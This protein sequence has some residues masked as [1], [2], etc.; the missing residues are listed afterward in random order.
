MI[1]QIAVDVAEFYGLLQDLLSKEIDE[2]HIIEE[3]EV[4]AKNE[5]LDFSQKFGFGK[6]TTLSRCTSCGTTC[7]KADFTYNMLSLGIPLML[8]DHQGSTTL[9]DLIQ[10]RNNFWNNLKTCIGCNKHNASTTSKYISKSPEVMII[11]IDRGRSGFTR[12]DARINFPLRNFIPN[13]NLNTNNNASNTTYDLFAGIFFNDTS[14][15]RHFKAICKMKESKS[16][17]KYNDKICQVVSFENKRQPSKTVV[18]FMSTAYILFYI[19]S[20]TEEYNGI[21][22]GPV[23]LN[24]IEKEHPSIPTNICID[25]ETSS[26][27]EGEGQLTCAMCSQVIQNDSERGYADILHENCKLN[28]HH[29]CLMHARECSFN[30]EKPVKCMKCMRRISEVYDSNRNITYGHNED[31]DDCI[32]C[33]VKLNT[34]FALGKVGCGQC[35]QKLHWRCLAAWT[36]KKKKEGE[37]KNYFPFDDM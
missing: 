26:D 11:Q 3:E 20:D 19:Q 34:R 17:C 10:F 25:I 32:W 1:S 31:I 36:N 21:S 24:D 4:C 23:I 35:K 15:G 27:S 29:C 13:E 6:L 16:W 7:D 22:S 37:L 14:S 18:K 12:T 8:D 33:F 5:L 9:N 2:A 30:I 28:Y